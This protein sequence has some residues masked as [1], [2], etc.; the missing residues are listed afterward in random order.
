MGAKILQLPGSGW[1]GA[2]QPPAP[3]G[4]G[5]PRLEPGWGTDCRDSPAATGRG[6]GTFRGQR[7]AEEEW[8]HTC[9]HKHVFLS[10]PPSH[11]CSA[12]GLWHSPSAAGAAPPG[13]NTLIFRRLV[14][15]Q[16]PFPAP[17]AAWRSGGLGSVF[18]C[19]CDHN[20]HRACVP[21]A[22]LPPRAARG[23]HTVPGLW[24][25]HDQATAALHEQ[26]RTSDKHGL[27]FAGP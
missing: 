21:V 4:V 13:V 19:P 12:P 25:C 20:E 16:P 24:H 6:F 3:G 27:R 22:L 1:V 11:V 14:Q 7:R 17:A 18:G 8:K 15:S 10:W 5:E 2:L 26:L 9:A 23:T